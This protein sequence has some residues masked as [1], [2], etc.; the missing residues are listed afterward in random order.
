MVAEDNRVKA[1]KTLW[2]NIKEGLT[3]VPKN[4]KVYFDRVEK[5]SPNIVISDFESWTYLYAKAHGL[6]ILSIDNMQ[7]IHRCEHE[8]SI[9]EGKRIEFELVKSFVKSKLPGCDEYFISTFFDVETR[10][11]RTSLYPPILRDDI[12]EAT[13]TQGE[14]I[15][16]YQ[17]ATGFDSLSQILQQLG[18]ECRVYGVRRDL[19]SDEQEG[20][21][22]HRPFSE[23]TFIE[24]LA[25]A[26]AVI[27]SAGFTLMGECVYLRKPMVAIPLGKQF[28]QLFNARYLEREGFGISIEKPSD[29]ARLPQFLAS[30]DTYENKLASYTQAGNTQIL[31]A[32]DHFIE[33][34]V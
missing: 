27:G 34:A 3:G 16:V 5:F 9:L 7:C 6:P 28:E 22:C 10:K 1:G 15:L 19:S 29:L 23:T 32:I 17:T 8:D 2:S 24:D 33:N 11:D 30:I 21:L 13:P 31:S 14:H 12:L 20:V 18:I 4:I 25:S 26:K